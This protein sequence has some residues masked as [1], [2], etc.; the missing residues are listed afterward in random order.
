LQIT[1]RLSASIS[2]VMWQTFSAV[3]VVVVLAG[4]AA[5]ACGGSDGRPPLAPTPTA[6]VATRQVAGT[7]VDT[8]N[9]PVGGA[10]LSHGSASTESD[11]DGR[12][13]LALPVGA[14]VLVSIDASGF[15]P[16]RWDLGASPDANFRLPIARRVVVTPGEPLAVSLTT[17]DLPYYVGEPYESDYC[18]PCKLIRVGGEAGSASPARRVH[19]RWTEDVALGM[20]ASNGFI[21]IAAEV[22]GSR[23]LSVRTIGV[24]DSRLLYV[25]VPLRNTLPQPIT[26]S[27]TV[28]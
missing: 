1:P 6:P 24:G 11:P 23:H 28:E 14:S 9:R 7:V 15:E 18:R 16:R 8:D 27:L 4:L 5:T 21:G 17:D 20:W 3:R 25:G 26:F 19:L 13:S 2:M 12:F 22:V 10:R